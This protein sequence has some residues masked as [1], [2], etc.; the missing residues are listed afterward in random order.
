MYRLDT[1]A[2]VQSFKSYHFF[3]LLG[4]SSMLRIFYDTHFSGVQAKFRILTN[5]DM[6]IIFDSKDL[7]GTYAK[8]MKLS[9]P[10]SENKAK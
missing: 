6:Q 10:A 4:D 5:P 7:K 3:E 8:V 1:A 9:I 2:N